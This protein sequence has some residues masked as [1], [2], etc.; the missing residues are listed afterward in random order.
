MSMV[1]SRGHV[2]TVIYLTTPPKSGLIE[3]LLFLNQLKRDS[4]STKECKM[5]CSNSEWLFAKQGVQRKMILGHFFCIF[6][7]II[8]CFVVAIC[9]LVHAVE[10]TYG[11]P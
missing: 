7:I 5:Q 4:F 8:F 9:D 11:L 10:A 2:E 3:N 6:E 1:N